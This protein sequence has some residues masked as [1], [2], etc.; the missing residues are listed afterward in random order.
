MRTFNVRLRPETMYLGMDKVS[1]ESGH[2]I[3]FLG[4]EKKAHGT[5]MRCYRKNL[6]WSDMKL[7]RM[8]L[9]LLSS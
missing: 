1:L 5:F 8:M 6:C 3:G 2:Q 7:C 4:L 9:V